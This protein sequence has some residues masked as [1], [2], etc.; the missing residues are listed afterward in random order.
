MESSTQITAGSTQDDEEIFLIEPRQPSAQHQKPKQ[1]HRELKDSLSSKNISEEPLLDKTSILPLRSKRT[2]RLERKTKKKEKKSSLVGEKSLFGLPSELV[3]AILGF[4][5][6][7]DVFTL[8]RVNS[9]IREFII[10]SDNQISQAII[11]NRYS[12]LSKSFP[13]PRLI[14]TVDETIKAILLS[15]RHQQRL[16]IHKSP[17]QH[18]KPANPEVTCSCISCVM[19]WN[20]LNLIMDL[21][22]WQNSLSNREPIPMIPHGMK[23]QWNTDL[24]STHAS[25]VHMAITKPLWYARLLEKHLHT[26]NQTLTRHGTYQRTKK[27][28]SVDIPAS[29]RP[30]HFS[31]EDIAMETDSFLARRGPPSYELP[32]HR[33]K[34][35]TLGAYVPN[36]RWDDGKWIYYG[37]LHESEIKWVAEQAQ[38]DSEFAAA[39]DRSMEDR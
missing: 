16:G 4:L 38:R 34:Y 5:R 24:M 35:Y 8:L 25:S 27:M 31:G 19:A 22:H 33:D 30:F 6:P 39:L 2:E 20:N 3:V 17:Y 9:W 23:P 15:S 32:Y 26:I 18:I 12:I 11:R 29:Q 10:R 21:A 37:D 28:S 7:S 14:N 13:R 1:K 36:R